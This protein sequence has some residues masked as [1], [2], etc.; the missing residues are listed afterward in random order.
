MANEKKY[1]SLNKLSIFL[2]NLSNKF[3]TKTEVQKKA[4][5]QFIT[6]EADD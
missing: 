4:E 6:W 3:A 1:V 5:V 2:N